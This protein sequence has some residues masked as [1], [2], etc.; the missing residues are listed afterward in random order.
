[1][2]AW[3]WAVTALVVS[4]AIAVTYLG[5][6]VAVAI[7]GANED[8]KAVV[9]ALAY[10]TAALAAPLAFGR[11]ERRRPAATWENTL[12]LAAG[13]SLLVSIPLVMLAPLVFAM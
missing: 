9:A 10:F 5:I 13:G 11:R 3:S 6:G 2:V 7:M 4:V 12:R 1:M 8:A